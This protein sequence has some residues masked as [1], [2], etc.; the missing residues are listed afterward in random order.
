MAK[1]VSDEN[2]AYF[3]TLLAQL[4]PTKTEVNN[5]ISTAINNLVNSAPGTLDTLGELATAI[6][7][8]ESVV[9][10]LNSAIGNKADKSALTA[11]ENKI[12]NISGKL[13]KTTYEYNKELAI[14]STGKVLVGKFPMYD[15]NVTISVSSTTNTTFYGT[16]VI[17]TQNINDSHGGTY[18]ANVYNDPTGTLS[19]AFVVKYPT[20]SRV[21]EVYCNFPS[22]SKNLVHIQAVSLSSAPSNIVELIT[23]DIPTD[24]LVTINNVL[25][26]SMPTNN[27]QL[28]NGAGYVTSSGSVAS[29]TKATQDSDGNTIN[30]T[31]LKKSGDSINAN[32]TL[33]MGGSS[34]STGAK[35]MW[36]T[37][38]S[39]TPYIGYA[40]D[41]SDGTFMVGS[42]KGTTYQSGLAIGGG[43]GNLLWKGVKVATVNDNIT[44]N[45]ATATNATKLNNQDASY[46]LN[47]NNFTNKPNIPTTYVKSVSFSGNTLTIADTAGTTTISDIA[48]LSD[49]E[50]GSGI[51]T[52]TETNIDLSLLDSGVYL[53]ANDATIWTRGQDNITYSVYSGNVIIAAKTYNASFSTHSVVGAVYR[54]SSSAPEVLHFHAG[55]GADYDYIAKTYSALYNT[56]HYY[57]VYASKIY[58][59]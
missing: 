3:K 6:Q 33:V 19:S 49:L 29:A 53:V 31:Y 47:Y 32:S 24:S 30:T 16:L 46:Y 21:F 52:L 9:A 34:N 55:L 26:N 43:S 42:L 58:L 35:I 4:Y 38:S 59:D 50:G 17:A 5:S 25:K 22:W 20:N 54:N 39:N 12:P 15:S 28:T 41:Q 10:A 7:N 45:A 13:D 1:Y 48:R 44:G 27:N 51:A 37:V 14:G 18:V 11:V 23:T 2:L 57:A 56:A 8:N 40:S 36:N